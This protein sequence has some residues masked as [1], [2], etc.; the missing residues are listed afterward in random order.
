VLA[1]LEALS[2][3]VAPHCVGDYPNFVERPTDASAFFD[4]DTWARLRR[5]KALYDPQDLFKGNHH[6]PPADRPEPTNQPKANTTRNQH[7][8]AALAARLHAATPHHGL[9]Y[10]PSSSGC[11]PRLSKARKFSRLHLQ[12]ASRGFDD[13]ATHTHTTL[14]RP[15]G[16]L[17]A[18]EGPHCQDGVMNRSERVGFCIYVAMGIFCMAV[19]VAAAIMVIVS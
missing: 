10:I 5:V 17:D 6:V 16:A 11:P 19:L 15:A 9:A 1:E 18:V 14:A 7:A 4:P 3:S 8:P 12:A 2:A 13:V